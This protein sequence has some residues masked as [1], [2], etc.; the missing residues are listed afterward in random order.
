MLYNPSDHKYHKAAK[1]IKTNAQPILDELD[2]IPRQGQSLLGDSVAKAD[3]VVTGTGDLEPSDV[4][5]QALLS[6]VE[7]DDSRDY[8][9]SIFTFELEKPKPPT[10]PPSPPKIKI[11][12]QKVTAAEKKAKQA[13]KLERAAPTRSTRATQALNR[14]FAEEA[15][16]HPSS[17]SIEA[18]SSA[19]ALSRKQ[20]PG[21]VGVESFVRIS[22]K[23]R[24]ARERALDPVVQD[25]NAADLF[26]RF[27]AGWVLPEGS[28]RRR[29]ERVEPEHTPL[30]TGKLFLP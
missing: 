18:E 11:F 1:R 25:V 10:P 12:R 8:L 23:E 20:G 6:R 24:R 14:A 13:V 16:I 17:D 4:L 3:G 22:D 21:V 2:Y 28:K 19:M 9:S 7:E 30:N 15:G 29:T 27:N 26:N 5:L